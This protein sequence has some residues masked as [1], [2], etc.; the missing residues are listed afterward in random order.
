MEDDAGNII[1]KNSQGIIEIS[2]QSFQLVFDFPKRKGENIFFFNKIGDVYQVVYGKKESTFMCLIENGIQTNNNSIILPESFGEINPCR[3]GS[4]TIY[5]GVAG[6]YLFDGDE[7]EKIHSMD[8]KENMILRMLYFDDAYW[9]L[10]FNNGLIQI[11]KSNEAS[12]QNVYLENSATT[13]ICRDKAGVAHNIEDGCLLI[14]NVN[15]DLVFLDI[16]MPG[17]SGFTL[18][19]KIST[20]NFKVIFTTA[21]DEFA[22]SAIKLGAFD[23]LLKPIA[24]NEL[25][26]TLERVKVGPIG[27]ADENYKQL[28]HL[29]QKQSTGSQKIPV[30]HMNGITFLNSKDIVRCT[31]DN[32]YTII[33]L[34]DNSQIISSKTLK[35]FDVILSQQGFF[36]VHRSHLI[37]INSVSKL[38]K[39]K[40]ALIELDDGTQ[41]ELA[42]NKKT[43]FLSLFEGA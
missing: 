4:L 18:F 15:P 11:P 26:E 5:S 2:N 7:F 17:G 8:K 16:N 27:S 33:H 36:R 12:I 40:P 32:N 20:I 24:L 3:L 42:Q 39:G 28:L 6:I 10:S 31:A 34:K 22:I 21:H 14:Q 41:V 23:Y 1:I 25:K 13:S 37:S 38:L 19:D 35:D 29:I 9:V 30:A 43:D